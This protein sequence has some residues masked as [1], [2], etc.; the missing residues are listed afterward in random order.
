MNSCTKVIDLKL[1]STNPKYVIEGVVSNIAD[2][3]RVSISKTVDFNQQ[4]SNPISGATVTITTSDGLTYNLQET[5]TGT[6]SVPGLTGHQ[7]VRYNMEVTIAGEKFSANSV[8]PVMIP[9]D[10]LYVVDLDLPIDGRKKVATVRFN[11]PQGKGNA[12]KFIQYVNGKRSKNYFVENDELR[13]GRT[14]N[15]NLPVYNYSEDTQEE[16][17]EKNLKS[18]DDVRVDMLCIEPN[19][20]LYWY[21]LLAGS[22]GQN[23]TATPTNPVSNISGNALG[24]FSAQT[25]SA[26]TIKVP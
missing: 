1:E 25:I 14:V 16:R 24:Y 2:S 11:D 8:M 26:K 6:Y 23:Q 17:D 21:S 22:T 15:M 19:V 4:L 13:D 5:K 12:Y 7:G 3:S 18:G 20:Y 10:S 9:Y